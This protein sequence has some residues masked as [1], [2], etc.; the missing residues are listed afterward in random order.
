MIPGANLQ[1]SPWGDR[2][3]IDRLKGSFEEGAGLFLNMPKL[4]D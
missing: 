3:W 1:E 2:E 4:V